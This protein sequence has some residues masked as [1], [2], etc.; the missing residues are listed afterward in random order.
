MGQE[1]SYIVYSS[2]INEYFD[3]SFY[4]AISILT[5]LEKLLNGP[6]RIKSL[7][8]PTKSLLYGVS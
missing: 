6:I 2:R 8:D 5:V 7:F 4:G 1:L 3:G